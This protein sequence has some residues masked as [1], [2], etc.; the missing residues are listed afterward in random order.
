MVLIVLLDV[1][2]LKTNVK[3]SYEGNSVYIYDYISGILALLSEI[4]I[5]L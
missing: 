4:Y 1:V 2:L 3:S 5:S